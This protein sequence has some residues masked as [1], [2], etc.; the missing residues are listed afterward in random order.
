M[1]CIDTFFIQ[2]HKEIPKSANIRKI[3]IHNIIIDLIVH[4]PSSG[5]DGRGGSVK[6]CW[7]GLVCQSTTSVLKTC[8]I[9]SLAI[10]AA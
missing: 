7:Y 4:F 2:M 5:T 8:E 9:V 1:I 10:S 3:W 6:M